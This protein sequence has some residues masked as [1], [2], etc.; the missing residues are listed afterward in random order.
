[1]N[2]NKRAR[3][4]VGAVAL[5][6][7]VALAGN[8]FTATGVDF[9]GDGQDQFV[10]GTVGQTVSGAELASVEY[11]SVGPDGK[12]TQSIKLTFTGSAGQ[13]VDAV[14]NAGEDEVEVNCGLIAAGTFE[15][16]CTPVAPLSVSTLD[17]TVS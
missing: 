6:G 5:A 2:I 12:S 3:I 9:A 13:Q 1:M 11:I 14:L 4:L 8:A 16:T 10:G 7:S 17:I 15:V